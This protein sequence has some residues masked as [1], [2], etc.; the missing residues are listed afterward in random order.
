VHACRNRRGGTDR[1]QPRGVL[2]DAFLYGADTL[3]MTMDDVPGAPLVSLTKTRTGREAR[4][5]G[6]RLPAADGCPDCTPPSPAPPTSANCSLRRWTSP[7]TA[8]ATSGR[9]PTASPGSSDRSSSGDPLVRRRD[10]PRRRRAPRRVRQRHLLAQLPNRRER[11]QTRVS[12]RL[13]VAGGPGERSCEHSPDL[14]SA[15]DN[16]P[17]I[18]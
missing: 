5:A 11:H 8:S 3:E 10:P 9:P 4:P 12:Q 7:W 13:L 18:R 6:Q 17:G 16:C 1:A 15:R 14:G 2:I